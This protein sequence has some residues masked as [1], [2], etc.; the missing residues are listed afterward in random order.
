MGKQVA[1]GAIL[2]V[3]VV[4]IACAGSWVV[5]AQPA[6]QGAKSSVVA[7][8]LTVADYNKWRAV[9]D[10]VQSIRD[11]SAISKSRVFRGADNPNEILVLNETTDPAKAREGLTSTEMRNAMQQSG[12]V[13]AP[14]IYVVQP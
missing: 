8:E 4:A 12:V 6:N 2:A 7:V 14:R 9:Y 13:G 5:R 1:S 10:G 3:A 11:R